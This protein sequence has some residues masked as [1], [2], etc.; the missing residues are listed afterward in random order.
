ME[1]ERRVSRR[2]G[3]ESTL[4]EVRA[5]LIRAGVD[6]LAE[7]GVSLGL[8]HLKL[9]SLV[10]IT[11]V[12]RATAYRSLADDHLNPQEKIRFDVLSQVLVRETGPGNSHL[13]SD[14]ISEALTD[15]GKDLDSPDLV[16]RSAVLREVIRRGAA[17]SYTAVASSSERAILFAAYGSITS[18]R[19][20][21]PSWQLER[22]RSGEASLIH[23][24]AAIYRDMAALFQLQLRV[25]VTLEHLAT[26]IASFTEGLGLRTQVNAHLDEIMLPSGRDGELLPWTLNGIGIE[27]IVAR[28]FEPID[29]ADPFVDL[30][31]G[32]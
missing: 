7:H 3:P 18:Q 29:P 5:Q 11:G 22:L 10:E 12:T 19:G 14:V 24:F 6:L 32:F 23:A 21:A 16:R 28:F 17:A 31:V 1:T 20:A 26:I 9:S 27:A 13:V 2:P 4:A 25:G 30:T 8:D 15:Y